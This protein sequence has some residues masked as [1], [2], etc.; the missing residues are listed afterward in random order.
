MPRLWPLSLGM[1]GVDE[2]QRDERAAVL[3]PAGEDR[4]PIEAHVAG[5]DLGRR[6]RSAGAD[7]PTRSSIARD[8]ARA[9]QLATAWAGSSVSASS[10]SRRIEPQRPRAEGQ[11]GA[12]AVPKRL[13]TSGKS[14]PFDVGEEQRRAAGGDHAAV[15]LG[16]LEPR[17]D[18]GVDERPG[19]R[20]AGAGPGS[21]R[22]SG[23]AQC[24][25]TRRHSTVPVCG[26]GGLADG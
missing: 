2:G 3:G 21:A 22:R 12:R 23:K 9:P 17:V 5:H 11:L 24:A 13:V 20:R 14:A 19:R 18:A 4:Q 25:C 16:G 15:D 8:V 1:L 7:G 6:A 10:T 26:R